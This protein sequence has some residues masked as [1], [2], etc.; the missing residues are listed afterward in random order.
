MQITKNAVGVLEYE[1]TD[2]EGEV[3]DTSAGRAPLA[4]VHG[5]GS[6]IPGLENELEGKSAGAAF[7][8]K[9]PAE[10]A[11]G[12]RIEE[13]VQSVSRSH[14]PADVEL[15]VGMQFEARGPQGSQVVTVVKIDGDDVTLDGNHPLA[16]VTLNFDVKVVEVREATA[17]E[18]EHGHVH[19]EGAGCGGH[20]H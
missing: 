11:Y 6:L 12:P 17:E 15:Q 14:M 9:V 18:L 16:G 2:D 8:V 19:G 1:L 20:E 3:L 10:E 7:K 5:T 13:L 4:Y